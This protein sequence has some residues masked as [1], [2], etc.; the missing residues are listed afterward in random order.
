MSESAA[1]SVRSVR[2]KCRMGAA[3]LVLYCADSF[4][5]A[6]SF[7]AGVP[8]QGSLPAL[9]GPLVQAA[10]VVLVLVHFLLPAVK[11]TTSGF[12]RGPLT[13]GLVA[14]ILGGKFGASTYYPE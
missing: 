1:A 5:P 11:R 8:A 9:V 12:S 3:V 6:L 13:V 4:L 14:A 10:V 2:W 7:L